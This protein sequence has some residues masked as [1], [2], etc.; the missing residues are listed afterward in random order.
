MLGAYHVFAT[1]QQPAQRRGLSPR[2][3]QVGQ[4]MTRT[5]VLL[6]RRTDMWRA[7]VGFNLSHSLGVILLGAVV[8]AVGRS[9]P[10]FAREAAVFVPL[11]ASAAAAYLLLALKYW[12]RTPIIGCAL[13]LGPLP[14]FVAVAGG[15]TLLSVQNPK[16][17]WM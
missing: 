8:L 4:S 13:S 7:W 16:P 15:V 10:S 9:E 3:P 14:G 12:F 11:A 6:T 1:P 17:A 5:A 2:D